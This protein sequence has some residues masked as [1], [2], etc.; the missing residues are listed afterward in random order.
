MHMHTFV[1]SG[2]GWNC[3]TDVAKFFLSS[4]AHSPFSVVV[5]TSNPRHITSN[6]AAAH[7]VHRSRFAGAP[8]IEKQDYGDEDEQNAQNEV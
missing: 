7:C 5:M 2:H 1:A 3:N 4:A 6:P 8:G